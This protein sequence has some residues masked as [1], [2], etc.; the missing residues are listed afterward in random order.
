MH[1]DV[2]RHRI[3]GYAWARMEV[4]THPFEEGMLEEQLDVIY[5]LCLEFDPREL[6]VSYG[7]ACKLDVDALWKKQRIPTAELASF[8]RRSMA[9]GI[10]ELG[11]SGLHMK[12]VHVAFSFTLCH[13]AD[14]HFESPDSR[15]VSRVAGAWSEHDLPYY[16][17]S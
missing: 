9:E 8:V 10:F 2:D 1:T 15:L 3:S 13:E 6:D 7:W 12:G 5:E 4:R 17:V 16:E 14:I 11:G